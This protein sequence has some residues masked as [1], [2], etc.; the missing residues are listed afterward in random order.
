MEK[1]TENIK[2][3]CLHKPTWKVGY[4]RSIIS[5]LLGS[6]NGKWQAFLMLCIGKRA[7]ASQIVNISWLNKISS[8]GQIG[9]TCMGPFAS[10]ITFAKKK[11]LC[12]VQ[13]QLLYLLELN[14]ERILHNFG[15]VLRCLKTVWNF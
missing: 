15:C 7:K 2:I 3:I 12:H 11:N 6:F 9:S 4:H 8:K 14:F 5:G 13:K 1:L 10:E